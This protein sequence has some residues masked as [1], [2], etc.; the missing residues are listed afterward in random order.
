MGLRRSDIQPDDLEQLQ[1]FEVPCNHAARACTGRRR[2]A[3][4]LSLTLLAI[5]I[6]TAGIIGGSYAAWTAQTSNPSNAVTAGTL[7][8]T[9][10]KSGS[11]VFS[12]ADVTPG[13]T[14][15][16]T[17]V[18]ANSG[19]VPIAM[20]LTQ[21][22]VTAT[23]IEAS[24]GLKVYDQTRN[25]CYWPVDQV[26]ACPAGYGAW[27]AAATLNAKALPATSGAAK[28]PAGQA[29]TFTISWQL[30]ASSPNSDQ[31]KTGSFR[32]GWNGT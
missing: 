20:Q 4:R 19:S 21:D 25:R 23:G 31:G 26:G 1:L 10:S 11:S 28:W 12:A 16:G 5:G 30:A 6:A 24:L 8:I 3:L 7:S 29:H 17:V 18:V 9:N 14:G 27:N 32:L 2:R 15:S 13:D 22:N